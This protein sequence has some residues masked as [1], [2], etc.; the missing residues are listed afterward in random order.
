MRGPA[1]GRAA[2]AA[3]DA[4]PPRMAARSVAEYPLTRLPA[5]LLANLSSTHD[6]GA[7]MVPVVCILSWCRPPTLNPQTGALWGALKRFK[8][9]LLWPCSAKQG[10]GSPMESHGAMAGQYCASCHKE[11]RLGLAC[12]YNSCSCSSAEHVVWMADTKWT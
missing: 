3:S 6:W 9:L 5:S 8:S 11:F 10:I 4:P 7:G 12:C 1:A 2:A